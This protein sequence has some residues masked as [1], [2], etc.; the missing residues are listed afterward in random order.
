MI[1]GLLMNSCQIFSNLSEKA[2]MS[3]NPR[4]MG[5][6]NKKKKLVDIWVGKCYIYNMKKAYFM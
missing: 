6:C 5:Q 3:G 2:T 1:D 4:I